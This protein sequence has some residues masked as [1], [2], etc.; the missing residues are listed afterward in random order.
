[1]Q[2]FNLDKGKMA[3]ILAGLF[4][5]YAVYGAVS[6]F[7]LPNQAQAIEPAQEIIQL[8]PV[9]I[10]MLTKTHLFGEPP[11]VIMATAN[12][13]NATRNRLKNN[14]TEKKKPKKQQ[15]QVNT[16][17]VQIN[18]TVTG[19]LASN[20]QNFAA[21]MLKVDNKPEKLYKVGE[22]LGK[23]EVKL[24]SV[25]LESVVI[26]N[27]GN[28]QTIAMKRPGLEN[29]KNAPNNRS[30]SNARGNQNTGLIPEIPADLALPEEL[31]MLNS[32]TVDG[33]Y[34]PP[35]PEPIPVPEQQAAT[36][37]EL[38]QRQIEDDLDEDIRAALE[39]AGGQL[40][41]D[42]ILEENY[43]DHGDGSH[44]EEIPLSDSNAIESSPDFQ[45]PVF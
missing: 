2:D 32:Q 35:M 27:N 7:K 15:Q 31:Q 41:S 29:N 28:E 38:L 11:Q 21:A 20:D 26:D 33:A 10:Q 34:T 9:N 43:D 24:Q 42:E 17:P 45:M 1:M 16:K 14:N 3:M 37:D 8:D 40:D 18:V 19:L 25:E 23:P 39:E 13:V 12:K 22:D 4:C 30:V 5:L 44:D 36:E 6:E